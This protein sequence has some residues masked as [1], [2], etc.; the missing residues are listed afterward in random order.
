MPATSQLFHTRS[1]DKPP[2]SVHSRTKSEGVLAREL[3][4][5]EHLEAARPGLLPLTAF[6]K[7]VWRRDDITIY[8]S[9]ADG[10]IVTPSLPCR[11]QR[12]HAPRGRIALIAARI[13]A[14]SWTTYG[15][16][17]AALHWH[18]TAARTCLRTTSIANAHRILTATGS[19]GFRWHEGRTDDPVELLKAEGVRF[20]H[21]GNA[22][23]RQRWQ[24]DA[25]SA[26]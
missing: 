21:R 9:L 24:L 23:P 1:A 7:Q 2:G 12:Q 8:G 5:A 25:A 16:L 10:Y 19:L 14:G 22:D 15:D 20:S 13:P 3:R 18:P 11:R 26:G 4:V 17:A 6:S